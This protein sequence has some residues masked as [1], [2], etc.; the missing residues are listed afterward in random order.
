MELR[1]SNLFR[2]S[3]MFDSIEI[4]PA[5]PDAVKL[6]KKIEERLHWLRHRLKQ[7]DLKLSDVGRRDIP[8][9]E[10]NIGALEWVLR[11]MGAK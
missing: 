2:S 3:S 8:R 10:G 9:I 4:V 11:E 1:M 7:D 5:Q 6:R